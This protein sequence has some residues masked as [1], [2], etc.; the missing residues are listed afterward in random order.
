MRTVATAGHVDHGKS[1]LVL[2]LTGT[3]PDRLAEEKARN[4]TI[5]LGY[6]F[7][8]LPSGQVVGFVDV[9]GHVRFLKN[10][11]A[12]VGAVD[13]AMLVVAADDGWMPQTEEHL[14][15]L[16]LLGIVHGAVVLT[17]A[18][19][20]DADTVE[21]AQ[22][23]VHERL[24]D[25]TWAD[26]PLV[27]CDSVTGR[28][29]DEL[30]AT[31]DD[32][33]A[34]APPTPDRRRP[35]LW[36]DRTFAAR[37]AGTVVTGTL[38]GGVLH[39]DDELVI[40]RT[41]RRVRVRGIESGHASVA[42][43]APGARVALNLAGVEHGELARGDA[44]VR[45]A[46]WV[47]ANVVDV[48]IARHESVELPRGELLA[49]VGSGEHHV[50]LRTLDPD[51]RYARLHFDSAV[52]LA[53]G[54]HLVVRDSGREQTL[55]GATVVDVDPTTRPRDAAA[56]LSLPLGPR[57]VATHGWVTPDELA[58]RSGLGAREAAALAGSLAASGDAVVVGAWLVD[59]ATVTR[60]TARAHELVAERHAGQPLDAGLE[61][62]TLASALGVDTPRLRALLELADGLVVDRDVVATVDH[63]V[64]G[65]H[66]PAGAAL[67][68]ALDAQPFTPPDEIVAAADP[69]LVR[70]LVRDGT[71]VD[72]EGTIFTLAAVD[73]ARAVVRAELE[74]SGTVSVG[75][76]RDQLDST[77]KYVVPLLELF[78]REG[79]T[80]RRG[81]TRIAGPTVEGNG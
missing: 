45:A 4:L 34:A 2:A 41:G 76:M 15:I 37:G 20:V 8:T 54:D 28:G 50:K 77:R 43:V 21:L 69:A 74:R 47:L 3:D 75:A 66:S 80:R 30:R 6:A 73:R 49:Y 36:V 39:T 67:V 31:L 10:M 11:L 62:A 40:P 52:A 64:V 35:R 63:V 19:A 71:L 44:L 29:L 32:V 14:L 26:A 7:T 1:S 60:L 57:L 9:P 70:A 17:K 24:A 59:P 46:D 55:G 58:R 27:V 38:A 12:G 16:E 78:D 56:H 72:V 18:D 13:V 68:Q 22:L 79:V 33:L 25:S 81:D 65:A 51:G 5:D 42:E 53:P 23:L 61:L 48:E